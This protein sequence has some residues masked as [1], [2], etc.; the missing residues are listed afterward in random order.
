M[1]STTVR[2]LLVRGMLAGIGAGLLA[3]VVAYFIGIPSVDAAID[4]E[5][6]QAASA[7]GGHAHDAEEEL[8]SRAQQSTVG[9]A[10]GVLVFATALGGIAALAYCFALGRVGRFRARATAALVAGAGFV[11]VSLVPFL[12]YPANPPATSDP[13]SLDQRT[14][15]YFLMIA[16]SVLLGVGAILL[17]RRLAARL[18]DWNASVAAGAAFVAVVAVAM[19]FLPS[20]SETPKDFPA[21]VLWEFRLAALGIQAVLW[22]AFGLLFGHLAERVLEPR[23]VATPVSGAAVGGP[24]AT[25]VSE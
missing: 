14:T 15:L 23:A 5:S 17:G 6:A 2:T 1:N 18:G 25:G 24:V 12:K 21:T 7:A 3:S 16:L 4:Y 8:F 22:A 19:A 11:T 9:L 10:T 13:G 20:V